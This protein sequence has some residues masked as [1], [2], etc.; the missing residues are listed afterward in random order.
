MKNKIFFPFLGLIISIIATSCL[1]SNTQPIDAFDGNNISDVA[2]VW[3]RYVTTE[4]SGRE[5]VRKVELDGINKTIDTA[6]KVVTIK[7]SPSVNIIKSIPEPARSELSVSNIAVVVTLPT[8]ARISPVGNA[9]KL[10]VNGDWSID[11][12]YTV[13]AANGKTATWT[14][15]FSE[16]NIPLINKYDGNYTLTGTMVDYTNAALTGKYPANVSLITQSANSV[17]LWDLD[18]VNGYGHR[19]LNGATDSWYGDFSPVFTF[20]ANDNVISVTNRYGQPAGNGRS[21]ELDP[22]GVNKWDSSTK[23]LKVKYWMNQPGSTHRTLFD[24]TFTWK[25]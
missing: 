18:Y 19:I 7:V 22:S 23:T 6:S 17:A 8:A 3:Y 25:E 14:I 9:P 4:P 15:K 5:V 12:Q 13:Q 20:D 1:K 10:G 16:L 11:N 21:G 2:G 24:E